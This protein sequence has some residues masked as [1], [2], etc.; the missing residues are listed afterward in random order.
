MRNRIILTAFGDRLRSEPIQWPDLQSLRLPLDKKFDP[1]FSE[2]EGKLPY[3][4]I[5]IFEFC[6]HYEMRGT[7]SLAIYK[8]VKIR[9]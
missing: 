4:A 7:E 5:G 8:L 9:T 6:G 2:E 1:I 3:M